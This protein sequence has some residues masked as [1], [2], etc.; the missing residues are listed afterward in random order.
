MT[1]SCWVLHDGAAGN[2][3]QALALATAMGLPAQEWTLQANALARWFAPRMAPGARFQWGF[4]RTLADDPP[5]LAI[6]CGRLAALGTR[7]AAAAGARSVQ[8]LDPR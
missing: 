7:L 4:S 3:R 2:R 5:A 1:D 8:I 6:G